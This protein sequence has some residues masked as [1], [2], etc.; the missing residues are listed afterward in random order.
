M[1]HVLLLIACAAPLAA[2]NKQPEVHAQNASVEEVAN[3]V[4]AASSGE[5]M[6]RPGEWESNTTVEEMSIPGM[7]PQIQEQMKKA[8]ASQQTH[9][10]RSCVTEADVRRP[11][12][13]FFAGKN[14]SCRYDHFNMSGG[15]IDAVMHCAGHGAGEQMTMDLSGTYARENYDIH[16]VMNNKGREAGESMMVKAHTVSHRV[17]E[18]TSAELAER[19]K[20]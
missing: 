8:M 13:N 14:N 6:V 5:A 15:K 20:Q 19:A 3:K 9:S 1:K 7:P 12:E 4:Q 17:G 2:C 10:F 11:K 16:M 18:C